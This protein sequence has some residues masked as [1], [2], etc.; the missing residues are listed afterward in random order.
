LN[1]ALTSSFCIKVQHHSQN[2][3][4]NLLVERGQLPSNTPVGGI[5]F[6]SKIKDLAVRLE[7]LHQELIVDEVQMAGT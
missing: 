5:A 4:Y 2:T 3:F 6:S 7:T 1:L